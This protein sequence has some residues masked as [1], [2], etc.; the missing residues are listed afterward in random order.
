MGGELLGNS[1]D[2]FLR[3]NDFR[4][5]PL[6]HQHLN[7]HSSFIVGQ[8]LH[9]FEQ[10]GVL[11]AH[12]L[13]KLCRPHARFLQLLEGFSGVHAL[14]L[15]GVANQQ[16]LILRADLIQEVTH[17][18]RRCQRGFIDHIEMFVRGIAGGLQAVAREEALQRVRLDYCV[19]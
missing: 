18:L 7:A 2:T 3:V 11:L 19:A 17:L 9:G 16:Y 1:S 15:A 14:M 10:C 5:T 13:V 8:I 6:L 12:D 4:N